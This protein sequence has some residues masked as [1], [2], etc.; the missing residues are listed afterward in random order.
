MYHRGHVPDLPL[1]DPSEA[2]KTV[3]DELDSIV[4]ICIGVHNF[5]IAVELWID[6]IVVVA[7]EIGV[8]NV[9]INVLNSCFQS[10]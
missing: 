1:S 8:Y 6:D 5:R 2:W 4:S 10:T 7:L 9:V 3:T